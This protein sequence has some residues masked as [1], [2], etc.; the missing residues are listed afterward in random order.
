MLSISAAYC[1]RKAVQHV[2]ISFVVPSFLLG[3]QQLT[4]AKHAWARVFLLSVCACMCVCVCVCMCLSVGLS[5][6]P[7]IIGLSTV[8]RSSSELQTWICYELGYLDGKLRFLS[9]EAQGSR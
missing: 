9:G 6:C 8:F 2:Y 3:W 7:S 1:C 4:L 5:I